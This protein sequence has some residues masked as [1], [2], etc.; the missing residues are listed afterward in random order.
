LSTPTANLEDPGA[1]AFAPPL[2]PPD[3]HL[4]DAAAAAAI[5]A[6]LPPPDE[7]LHFASGVESPSLPSQDALLE[8]VG[9][10]LAQPSPE[11]AAGPMVSE[12]PKR[13]HAERTVAA[14]EQ[15]LAAI[16]VARPERS[17]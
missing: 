8:D 6:L 4:D 1:A 14:L 3:E 10:A 16:H 12:D 11:L 13:D 15:W 17:A 5:A 9:A 2:P 7:D